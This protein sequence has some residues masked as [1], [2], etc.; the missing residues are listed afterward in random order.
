ARDHGKPRAGLVDRAQ[1][2]VELLIRID[3]EITLR[4]LEPRSFVDH[5]LD[6]TVLPGHHNDLL[7]QNGL[8]DDLGL[9]CLLLR[10]QSEVSR[11]DLGAR[12]LAHPGLQSLWGDR[13]AP[14]QLERIDRRRRQ[15]GPYRAGER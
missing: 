1:N 10:Q 7:A 11:H 14:L 13:S 12:S 5:A 3:A 6:S 4:G 9:A 2:C 15:P 8:T